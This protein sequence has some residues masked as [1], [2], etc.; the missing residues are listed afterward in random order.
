MIVEPDRHR[1]GVY[2]TTPTTPRCPTS[3][4]TPPTPIDGDGD[5]QDGSA[6]EEIDLFDERADGARRGGIDREKWSIKRG[7]VAWGRRLRGED[8]LGW[9]GGGDGLG[10]VGGLGEGQTREG[11]GEGQRAQECPR[12]KVLAVENRWMTW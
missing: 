11:E 1:T 9:V 5:E 7:N 2:P 8:W 6:R 10:V 12:G 4:R 3:S